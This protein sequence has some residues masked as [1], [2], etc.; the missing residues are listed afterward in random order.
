M[1]SR[2]D[3]VFDDFLQLV[4]HQRCSGIAILLDICS[5]HSLLHLVNTWIMVVFCQLSSLQTSKAD[6]RRR[7]ASCMKVATWTGRVSGGE[8]ILFPLTF[9]L[10]FYY[11]RISRVRSCTLNSL[12]YSYGHYKRISRASWQPL[13]SVPIE[14]ICTGL[15]WPI[16][17][18]GINARSG[19][20]LIVTSIVFQFRFMW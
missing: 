13:L 10:T 6:L 11:L 4:W 1:H 20:D 8:N 2:I 18:T 16:Q 5:I 3:C 17:A 19:D 12:S 14:S 15:M 9:Q 7:N